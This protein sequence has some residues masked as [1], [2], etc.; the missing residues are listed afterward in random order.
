MRDGM[1]QPISKSRMG[2]RLI[3]L[4]PYTPELQ[5]AE[6]LW[7]LVD[8]PIANKHFATIEEL[9]TKIAERCVALAEEPEQIKNRTG[10]HWWPKRIAPS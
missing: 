6:T 10:F 2:I 1:A 8:E 5:P 9:K 3:Y 4:P 7:A